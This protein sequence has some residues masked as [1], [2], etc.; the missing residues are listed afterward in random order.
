MKTSTNLFLFTL[1]SAD[2]ISLVSGDMRHLNIFIA[3]I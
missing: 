1:A 3:N 2:I